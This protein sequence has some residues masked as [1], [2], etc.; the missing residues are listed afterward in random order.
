MFKQLSNSFAFAEITQVLSLENEMYILEEILPQKPPMLLLSR[1]VEFNLNEKTLVSEIDISSK[2]MFFDI[3]IRGIPSYIG[4]K[5]MAQT[6]G[7]LFGI[8]D[9]ISNKASQIEFMIGS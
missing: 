4:L 3:E 5:Y 8:E 2:S 1:V 6:V 7:C 9:L